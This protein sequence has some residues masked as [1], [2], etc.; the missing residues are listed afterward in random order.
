[1]QRCPGAII[2][3]GG[4]ASKIGL[5]DVE[6]GHDTVTG[7]DPHKDYGHITGR[8]V[9]IQIGDSDIFASPVQHD[10]I[11]HQVAIGVFVLIVNRDVTGLHNLSTPQIQGIYTGVYQNWQQ[12]CDH[13]QCGP[14]LPILP[15]S[16]TINSGTGVTFEQ[17]VLKGVATIPGLGLDSASA[18]ED[19]VQDVESNPGS[20]GYAQFYL[21]SQAHNVTTLS[22]DGQD[23]HNFSLIERGT[24]RFWNIEHMYTR[25]AGSPLAQSFLSFMGSST[26][27]QLLSHFGFLSLTDV[28]Q[29]IRQQHVLEGQ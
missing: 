11:D 12:I 27:E 26:G 24:Y 3:V 20:I 25:G 10:L 22:I 17:Y 7:V 1:M 6:Q 29:D 13:G 8:D 9:P 2:T 23:P 19:V 14:D 16:R 28:P 18:N 4:G 21:A 15:V 5:A